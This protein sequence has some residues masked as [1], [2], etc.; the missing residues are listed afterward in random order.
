MTD[1]ETID[2]LVFPF[3]WLLRFAVLCVSSKNEN[4]GMLF[5]VSFMNRH[6]CAKRKI[7]KKFS[8]IMLIALCKYNGYKNFFATIIFGFDHSGGMRFF[9]GLAVVW[10]Y[11]YHS[12]AHFI[13]NGK[14][15][16]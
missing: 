7:S 16:G 12:L 4:N 9:S 15:Y 3:C 14:M 13:R 11:N 5:A 8:L 10:V 2:C 1:F 6:A